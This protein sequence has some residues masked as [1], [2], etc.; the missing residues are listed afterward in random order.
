MLYQ[1]LWNVVI[2]VTSSEGLSGITEAANQPCGA[3][4]AKHLKRTAKLTAQQGPIV[5]KCF[6]LRLSQRLTMHGQKKVLFYQNL[7]KTSERS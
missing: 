4:E 6:R 5:K 2:A 7:E 1:A 3:A